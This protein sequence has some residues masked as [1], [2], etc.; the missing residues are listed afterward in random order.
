MQETLEEEEQKAAGR[1][2]SEASLK[3]RDCLCSTFVSPSTKVQA[4]ALHEVFNRHRQVLALDTALVR[5]P[6]ATDHLCQ[7]LPD[8]KEVKSQLFF[9]C[10]SATRQRRAS[11]PQ[12]SP[13]RQARVAGGGARASGHCTGQQRWEDRG[14]Q[15]GTIPTSTADSLLISGFSLFVLHLAW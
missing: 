15:D 10:H 3:E 7:R 9:A 1:F 2:K 4:M 5:A 8:H 13:R 14:K 11:S 12:C 6:L